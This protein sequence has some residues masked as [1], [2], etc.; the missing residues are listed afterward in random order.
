MLSG[1]ARLPQFRHSTRRAIGD[2]LGNVLN[3]TVRDRLEGNAARPS[4]S[5]CS[6]RRTMLAKLFSYT[7]IGIDATPVE[8]EVD[9]SASS[10]PKTVLVGL[11]EAAV[12]E[13]THRVER[14]IVNS[15]YRRPVDRVVINLAPADLKKDA[16]GFDLPIALGLLLA[17]GQVA[18]DRPGNF[19]IVGELALTGETRPVKGILSMAIQAVAEGRDG[20][21]VPTANAAEAAVVEGLNVYPIGSLAE[22]VGF[23]SGQV[24]MDPESVDLDELFAQHSHM[25]EDFVDVKGQDYAKRALLIAAAGCHNVLMIGPPGTGK[26]LLAKRLPTILPPLTPAESLETTRIYSAMGRLQPG[27]PLMAV[28]PFCTPHHSVSDAGLVGGGNPPQ[29]GQISMAHKG[30]LFLDEMPEFNRKTLEVLRQPLEEGKVTISRAMNSSTFPADFILVAAM[31]PCPCGYRSDPR[32]ACSCTPPQVEKYLSQ[33]LRPPARPHRPARRGPR[34]PLHAARRDAP[35]PSLLRIPRPGA[36][37]ACPPGQAVRPQGPAGQRPD[38]PA[39]APQALSAQARS[40]EHPQGRHGRAWFV[41]PRSR[42][43]VARR[44]H[45]CRPRR[46]RRDQAAAHC[47]GGGI[48]V[49]RSERVDV[50]LT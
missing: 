45:H 14:A 22:A 34:R 18:F 44:P 42:Q 12:K 39:P 36:G 30:V 19:A 38:D 9:V 47:G 20:L 28:R 6:E 31:N 21:L 43:G 32:R 25:D 13:S 49:A 46:L 26:T 35:R 10:M 3:S 27:Q 1:R 4:P 15:G 8:V 5:G 37:S 33:D 23:L 50:E 41:G 16:N 24:D 29:P 2:Q 7:L 40:H 11:A 48:P 17:S